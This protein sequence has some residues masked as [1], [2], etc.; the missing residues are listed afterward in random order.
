MRRTSIEE[1]RK[2]VESKDGTLLSSEYTNYNSRLLIRCN[3]DN[4]EWSPT[5]QRIR[6]CG[7]WC[8]KCGGKVKLTYDFVKNEIEKRNGTLLSATYEHSKKPILIR[9]N[10]DN[11]EWETTWSRIEGD[12]WCPRCSKKEPISEDRIKTIIR[13]RDGKLLAGKVENSNSILHIRCNKDQY[14]WETTA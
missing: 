11:Y 13:D 5:W 2:F 3:K 1:I 14:D 8:P 9:C 10:K 6:Y 4:Y 7:R 12:H